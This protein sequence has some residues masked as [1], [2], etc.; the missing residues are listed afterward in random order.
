M[1]SRLAVRR[2]QAPALAQVV[3]Q[4]LHR[5]F[6]ALGTRASRLVALALLVLGLLAGLVDLLVVADGADRLDELRRARVVVV[7]LVI[8]VDHPA[9]VDAAFLG[10]LERLQHPRLV[11]HAVQREVHAALGVVD[12]PHQCVADLALAF[13]HG[14]VPR[15]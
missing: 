5:P 4:A 7:A 3:G 12:Q 10:S 6:E 13:V 15:G 1:G 14:P 11:T 8:A 2:D 9:D